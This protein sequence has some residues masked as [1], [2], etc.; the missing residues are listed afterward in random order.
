M[1]HTDDMASEVKKL[2]DN[3]FVLL[4]TMGHSTD[5]PILLEVLKTKQFPY[6]G[7]IGSKAKNYTVSKKTLKKPI[8]PLL[9]KMPFIA[10]SG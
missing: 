7:V 9:V 1:I 8:F 5:L 10:P 2:D 4:M 3:T 6:L